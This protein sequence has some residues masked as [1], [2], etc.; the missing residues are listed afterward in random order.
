MPRTAMDQLI[1]SIYGDNPPSKRANLGEA[2]VAAND[3]LLLGLIGREQVEKIAA[4]LHNG[5]VPYSTEDL[6]LSTALNFYRQPDKVLTLKQAQLM[7]RMRA[8]EWLQERK[9]APVLVKIFEDSLY[10]IYKP[11]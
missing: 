9:A 11:V 10:K 2:V 6:A 7:A 3:E 1:Q 5:P 4:G 8:L